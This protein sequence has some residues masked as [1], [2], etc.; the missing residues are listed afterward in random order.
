[1]LIKQALP[2]A[3]REACPRQV[4]A[5][6]C[7]VQLSR[8]EAQRCLPAPDFPQVPIR[9]GSLCVPF[10]PACN[11]SPARASWQRTQLWKETIP[12]EASPRPLPVPAQQAGCWPHLRFQF[13]HLCLPACLLHGLH[14]FLV[15]VGHKE[16]VRDASE[17]VLPC[18]GLQVSLG[19]LQASQELLELQVRRVHLQDDG[20]QEGG[21]A[22]QVDIRAAVRGLPQLPAGCRAGSKAEYP[23]CRRS[24]LVQDSQQVLQEMHQD[25][26][27][28]EEM[29][30][31]S[32]GWG[33]SSAPGWA[34][35]FH[36]G[37]GTRSVS[38]G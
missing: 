9:E 7:V 16:L 26:D 10:A 5:S 3:V 35:S 28:A 37:A 18:Q 29:L 17:E 6:G 24:L 1:M 4:G 8:K 14:P 33:Q 34:P 11:P 20:Q 30:C 15:E 21:L 19:S 27:L 36:Q 32:V 31:K 22:S 38:R 12:F 25:S 13:F 23:L 2:T